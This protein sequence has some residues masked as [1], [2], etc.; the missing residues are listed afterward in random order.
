[1]VKGETI[2]LEGETRT[3]TTRTESEVKPHSLATLSSTGSSQ[4]ASL[5]SVPSNKVLEL[6]SAMCFSRAVIRPPS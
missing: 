2:L 6:I 1:M 5:K 4:E 3:L